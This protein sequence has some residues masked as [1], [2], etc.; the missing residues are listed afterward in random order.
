MAKDRFWNAY[1]SNENVIHPLRGQ[2]KIEPHDMGTPVCAVAS[3]NPPCP[4][5]SKGERDAPGDVP[6]QIMCMHHVWSDLDFPGLW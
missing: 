1:K 3:K 4:P 2:I 5:L 6:P